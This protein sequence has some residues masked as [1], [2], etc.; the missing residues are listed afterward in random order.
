MPSNWHEVAWWLSDKPPIGRNTLQPP[1]VADHELPKERF[2]IFEFTSGLTL[3]EGKTDETIVGVAI[4]DNFTGAPYH[5][6]D[7]N[8]V[9]FSAEKLG[10][11][12]A[13]Q[14]LKPILKKIQE[15]Q[16]LLT[17]SDGQKQ[18]TRAEYLKDIEKSIDEQRAAKIENT[19]LSTSRSNREER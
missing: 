1:G 16:N 13:K 19:P 9:G 11:E 18:K 5:R 15:S 14:K 8:L 2:E 12:G 17:D 7:N 10:V 6:G 3:D 4:W